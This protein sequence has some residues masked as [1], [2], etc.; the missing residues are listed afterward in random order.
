MQLAS[1]HTHV[2]PA[3]R[4]QR[5]VDTC[6]FKASLVSKQE[7][8]KEKE[9]QKSVQCY[10]FGREDTAEGTGRRKKGWGRR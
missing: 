9:N 4:E 2:V 8:E 10:M 3:P 1:F 6:E 5:Q 7:K